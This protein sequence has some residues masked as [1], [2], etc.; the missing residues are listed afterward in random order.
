MWA[1]LGLGGEFVKSG[2]ALPHGQILRAVQMERRVLA[3]RALRSPKQY[4]GGTLRRAL[5]PSTGEALYYNKALFQKAGITTPPTTYD[6]LVADADKLDGRR[7]P[8]DHL[9]RH[10]Q[11][12]RDAAD[13][14][15]PGSQVRR[16]K[17]RRADG[18]EGGLEPTSPA[19][20]SPSQSSHKWTSKYILKPFMGIDNN[21]SFN[22]FLA[23]RA[24]MMLEGDWLVGQLA[25]ANKLD[26]YGLFPFP[27]GT[28]RLYGF[29]EYNYISTKSKN[30]DIAAKFLDYLQ[31]TPVQ[32][33]N[34][35][36]LRRD[37][38]EQER[39]VRQPASRS[40]SEW[41]EIFRPVQRRLRERRPG[42]PA[43]RDD[44]ILP[45][46][47]RGRQRQSR[48]GDGRRR[49]CRSSSPRANSG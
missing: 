2:L 15:D 14:R 22:L 20:P 3:G 41:A 25:D 17:A 46:D 32:Q 49:A 45:R 7:H 26:D 42:L 44:G 47:Q 5:T 37:L 19:P 21:Q 34:L 11:L 13:G 36:D 16:R 29:A 39:Q 12:A 23:G 18:D 1:G 24:A 28:D 35:G 48:S 33:A 43:G 8:G 9:R 31:S 40:I 6:E 27:T 4:P 10:R 30:P 38:G